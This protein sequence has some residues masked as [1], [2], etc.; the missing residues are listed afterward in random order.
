MN[1]IPLAAV[2]LL[3][4]AIFANPARSQDIEPTDEEQY[5]LELINRVRMNPADEGAWLANHPD[6]DIQ[7]SYDYFNVDRQNIIDDFKTYPPVPPLAFNET[8]IRAAR[9]HSKDMKDNNFQ[10][11]YRHGRKQPLHARYRHGLSMVHDR[12]KR[13]RLRPKRRT[14]PR[15]LRGRL[16]RSLP[17]P[18]QKYAGIRKRTGLER[19]RNRHSA[20]RFGQSPGRQTRPPLVRNARCSNT[21]VASR[22]ANRH[23]RFR[24]PPSNTRPKSSASSIRI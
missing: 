8:L 20:H 2:C 23:H 22:T 15:G 11:Q 7:S 1:R 10:G 13:L 5:M 24:R 17:R 16:G 6:R 19:N 9:R 21:A 14:R 18:P 4:A 3:F 12:R